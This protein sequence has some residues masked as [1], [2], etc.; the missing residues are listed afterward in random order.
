MCE[1]VRGRHRE[2]TLTPAICV[3]CGGSSCPPVEVTRA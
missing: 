2:E 3:L 1:T